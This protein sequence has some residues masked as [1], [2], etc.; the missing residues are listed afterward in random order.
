MQLIFDRTKVICTQSGQSRTD[1][2]IE[3][4]LLPSHLA[5]AIDNPVAFAYRDVRDGPENTCIEGELE[6]ESPLARLAILPHRRS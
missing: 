1:E 6:L 4:A 2:R 3:R 5:Q